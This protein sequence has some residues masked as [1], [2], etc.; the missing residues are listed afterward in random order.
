MVKTP[1]NFPVHNQVEQI[2]LT[3]EQVYGPPAMQTGRFHP[4]DELIACILSQHTSDKNS[5]RAFNNLKT[6]F[7]SWEQVETAEAESIAN[8]IRSGG[9][10]DSKAVRIKHALA[11][12]RADRGTL[13]LDFL[14]SMPDAEA[15][16]WLMNL[17]GVGPK[18]AAI[19]LCFALNRPVIPVDTHVFRVSWRLGLV[20]RKAGEGRAHDLLQAIVPDA[21]VFRFHVAL[22]T[23][24]RE[25]CKAQN[26]RCGL[27]PVQTLCSHYL[28][29]AL[30]EKTT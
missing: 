6:H 15:R 17:P 14:R 1:T 28:S 4:L 13:E 19:V 3:L 26:P 2:L 29:T 25:T 10:A 21:L 8:V 11:A 16:Q 5:L 9:L 27:C 7:P 30:S 20:P 24:G 23:H 22:I 12:I 18:T